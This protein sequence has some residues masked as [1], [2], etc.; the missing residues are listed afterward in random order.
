MRIQVH[1]SV[2]SSPCNFKSSY[3][4]VP[5]PLSTRSLI[6][7]R[8]GVP[9]GVPWENKMRRGLGTSRIITLVSQTDNLK[10]N[11][12]VTTNGASILET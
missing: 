5:R 6:C 1:I 11:V 3:T 10:M 12:T 9:N 4:L 7:W 2:F 8:S